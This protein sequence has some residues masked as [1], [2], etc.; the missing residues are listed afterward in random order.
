MNSNEQRNAVGHSHGPF[1]NNCP[2]QTNTTPTLIK[3]FHAQKAI[4]KTPFTTTKQSTRT[5]IEPSPS[6]Y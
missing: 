4:N 2:H 3:N 1:S 6:A 5:Q